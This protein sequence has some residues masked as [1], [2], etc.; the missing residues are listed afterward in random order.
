MCTWTS[1]NSVWSL[2]SQSREN[3]ACLRSENQELIAED[4]DVF[5]ASN[6]PPEGRIATLTRYCGLVG[7]W[8]SRL[9]P[10][11]G[12]AARATLWSLW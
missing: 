1:I 10:T 3:I 4:I 12:A 2:V 7:A 5:N 6:N 9:H 11:E 8:M